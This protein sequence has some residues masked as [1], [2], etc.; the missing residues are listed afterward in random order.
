MSLPR[1]RLAILP[2]TTHVTIVE[3]GDW[4]VQMAL[5]FFEAEIKAK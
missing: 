3:R 2:G 1:A 4:I 5:E